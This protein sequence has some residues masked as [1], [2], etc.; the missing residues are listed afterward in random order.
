MAASDAATGDGGAT[1]FGALPATSAALAVPLR[2]GGETV[3]V[4]YADDV[5]PRDREAPSVWPE[6]LEVLARHA[7]RCLEVVT[8]ARVTQPVSIPAPPSP[9]PTPRRL[10]AAGA[11]V[12]AGARR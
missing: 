8:I 6:S 2:V 1:P 3:G 4:L 9:T 7:C 5:S 12:P 10:H 11:H